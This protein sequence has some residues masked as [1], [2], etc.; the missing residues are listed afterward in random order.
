MLPV[1][2]EGGTMNDPDLNLHGL[3]SSQLNRINFPKK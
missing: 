3:L 1:R 2:R